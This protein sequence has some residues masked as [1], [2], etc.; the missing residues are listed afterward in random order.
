MVWR[1]LKIWWWFVCNFGRYRGK[2]KG[3]KKC[4]PCHSRDKKVSNSVPQTCHVCC[5]ASFILQR[6]PYA[7][8][9]KTHEF[10]HRYSAFLASLRLQK[11]PFNTIPIYETRVTSWLT[12]GPPILPTRVIRLGNMQSGHKG[13]EGH[14]PI[15]PGHKSTKCAACRPSSETGMREIA[16]PAGHA[17][18]LVMS[19]QVSVMRNHK[20]RKICNET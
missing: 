11:S 10:L 13:H 14:T 7:A 18:L 20:S 8:L 5:C 12:A 9:Q 15:I 3:G 17:R 6:L 4:P 19:G 2:T 1:V 16:H